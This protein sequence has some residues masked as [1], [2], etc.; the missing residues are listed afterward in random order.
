MATVGSTAAQETTGTLVTA[1]TCG[2]PC[3]RKDVNN[4]GDASRAG[5][6]AT[7]ETTATRV[8]IDSRRNRAIMDKLETAW[9]F[10][11]EW[12]TA[13]ADMTGRWRTITAAGTPATAG[14]LGR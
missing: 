1:R 6:Q 10:A 11:T 14:V 5:A 7:A 9:V 2:K 4:S 8:N 3:S 13:T 12:L